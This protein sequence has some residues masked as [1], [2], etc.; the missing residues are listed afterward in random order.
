LGV[1]GKALCFAKQRLFCL[2]DYLQLLDA[3]HHLANETPAIRSKITAAV[4][5]YFQI[6]KEADV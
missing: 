1:T 2:P 6:A 5:F 3:A 4:D